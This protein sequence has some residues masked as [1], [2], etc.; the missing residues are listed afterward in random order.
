[1][2]RQDLGR[3]QASCDERETRGDI[4][5]LGLIPDFEHEYGAW[6]ARTPCLRQGAL[7]LEP[8]KGGRFSGDQARERGLV[9]AAG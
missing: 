4:G 6:P 3:D 5:G 8:A 1:M 2:Q 9:G 7:G